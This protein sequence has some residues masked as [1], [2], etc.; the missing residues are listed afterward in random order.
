MRKQKQFPGI[1]TCTQGHGARKGP[2]R[3]H[4]CLKLPRPDVNQLHAPLILFL[5]SPILGI[6][7]YGVFFF[8]F[9]VLGFVFI[10]GEEKS[11]K[12]LGNCLHFLKD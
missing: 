10:K 4:S 8:F 3:G 1:N 7:Q 12:Y 9:K 5:S 2:D 6:I 11:F